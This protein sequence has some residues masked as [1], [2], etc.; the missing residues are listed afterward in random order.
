[1][2][3]NNWI[4]EFFSRV[5]V[6]KKNEGFKISTKDESIV[7]LAK[8]FILK[9]K[10]YPFTENNESFL[11]RNFP[12]QTK[13]I[14]NIVFKHFNNCKVGDAIEQVKKLGTPASADQ[15]L[16]VRIKYNKQL[17]YKYTVAPALVVKGDIYP[18][19][20]Y[21]FMIPNRGNENEYPAFLIGTHC[22]I[23][24]NGMEFAYIPN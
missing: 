14:Y 9:T 17:Q 11:E 19:H 24:G 7:Q 3:V 6:N 4:T 15:L 21:A 13:G 12:I 18:E 16:A 5:F 23:G 1:M 2:K 10:W 8:K 22:E 20:S